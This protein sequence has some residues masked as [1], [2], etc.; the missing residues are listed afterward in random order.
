MRI[1]LPIIM[2][3]H[4]V[5]HFVGFAGAWQLGPDGFPYRTTVLDGRVDLGHVGVRIVGLLWLGLALGFVAVAIASLSGVPWWPLAALGVAVV[6]LL[7]SAL[8]FPEARLGVVMNLLII[9]ALVGGRWL[10]QI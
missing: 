3:L 6:S 2:A 4:G 1:V 10:G 9:A 7:L 5:A 8:E